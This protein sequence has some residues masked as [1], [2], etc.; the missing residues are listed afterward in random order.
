MK[1][2][3]IPDTQL[4]PGVPT[5]HIQWL[6]SYLIDKKPDVLVIIGDWA[7]MSSL[8]AYDIGK[9][10]FE[11]RTYTADIE[12][13]N[14]MLST[15]MEPVAKEQ[16]RL[17]KNRD[18][19]WHLRKEVRLGNHE[20]RI[21]KA[22]EADRKLEGLIS[23]DDIR[24]RDFGFNV[25]PFL[26]PGVVDGIAYSHYFVSGIMGRPVTTARAL[27]NKHHMS[28]VAGHQQG[29]DIAYATRADGSKITGIIAGSCYLHDEDYLNHQTNDHWRGIYMLHDV[30][31][32]SFDEM[33]V[34][35]SFLKDRY[36]RK[37]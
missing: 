34:S 16:A 22:I 33:P 12:I 28:C 1:H 26:Q 10:S 31:N 17:K 14:D 6:S 9:K 23:T 2:M 36:N 15:L 20:H 8:C 19:A 27:L 4:R 5:E 24:F 7:D 32:G 29:R 30:N 37:G 18:K 21:N 3:L 25:L 13:A 35:L 11:G